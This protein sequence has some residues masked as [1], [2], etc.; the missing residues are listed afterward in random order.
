M[1]PVQFNII[2][3]AVAIPGGAMALAS[4]FCANPECRKLFNIEI[5]N[6][7]KGGMPQT[8][9]SPRIASPYGN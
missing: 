9:G 5:V 8:D 1:D 6:Q 3:A 7:V 2:T 4:I